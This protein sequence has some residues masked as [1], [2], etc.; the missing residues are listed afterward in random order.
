MKPLATATAQRNL[1][2][3]ITTRVSAAEYSLVRLAAQERTR[4][5]GRRVTP[6]ALVRQIVVRELVGGAGK[7]A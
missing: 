3:T 5:E 7:A 1:Q 2:Q 4:V 6:S